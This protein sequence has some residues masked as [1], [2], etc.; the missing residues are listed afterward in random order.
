M[1]LNRKRK[2]PVNDITGQT[3]GHLLVTEMKQD[4]E[5]NPKG[6]YFAVC[7]CLLCGKED[8]STLPYN[9]KRGRTTSCGC[10]RDQ[11]E[12]MRGENHAQYTG[13]KEIRGKKWSDYQNKAQKRGLVFDLDI[14]KAWELYETQDRKC[15]L[16]GLPL[17]HHHYNGGGTAS[18]DRINSTKG[19]TLENVQ[20]VHKDVN[21]MKMDFPQDRFLEI[22]QLVSKRA[23]G[24][25][26]D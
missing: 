5:R 22:C 7:K 14:Q 12:K 15:A 25:D 8:F 6:Q 2:P 18:L 9:L 21:K 16:T 10:R 1:A 20:W 11:Y 4:L 19:Y 26:N 17:Q 3:Y 23:Q 13:Y 24:C